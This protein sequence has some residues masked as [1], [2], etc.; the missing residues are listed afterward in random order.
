MPTSSSMPKGP[1]GI[2]MIAIQARSTSSTEA[3]SLATRV[4]AARFIAVYTALK[5]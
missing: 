2:F 4:S 3:T 1:I 5:T